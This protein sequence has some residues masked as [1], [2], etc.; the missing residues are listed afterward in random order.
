MR[1]LG[2]VYLSTV[3]GPGEVTSKISVNQASLPTQ[4]K[5]Y[6]VAM[7]FKRTGSGSGYKG[8][9]K[10]GVSGQHNRRPAMFMIGNNFCPAA[11]PLSH[12]PDSG[13]TAPSDTWCLVVHSVSTVALSH[14]MH[15]Q[16]V[17]SSLQT[18]T[19]SRAMTGD[20]AVYNE[21][22]GYF[23]IGDTDDGLGAYP[24]T[25]CEVTFYPENALNAAEATSLYNNGYDSPCASGNL[26]LSSTRIYLHL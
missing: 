20:A 3:V 10:K 17:G 9:Y 21:A 6:S 24:G 14:K 12:C 18:W 19:D 8:V 4:T 1:F 5:E 2:P 13:V 23:D 7:W 26:Q 25:L 15:T 16:C 22:N 11:H